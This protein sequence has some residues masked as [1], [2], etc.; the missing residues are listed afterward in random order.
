MQVTGNTKKVHV[1]G[2][3]QHNK[4]GEVSGIKIHASKLMFSFVMV[5]KNDMEQIVDYHAPMP[6]DFTRS[7]QLVIVGA[8][9]TDDRFVAD[10]IL[11]KCPSKYQSTKMEVR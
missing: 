1:V 10:K 9:T 5:D 7:E 6:A 2:R 4:T 8:Y 11:L 3:L